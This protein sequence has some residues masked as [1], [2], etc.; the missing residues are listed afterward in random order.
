MRRSLTL[1]SDKLKPSTPA[2]RLTRPSNPGGSNCLSES[3]VRTLRS[4]DDRR[5]RAKNSKVDRHVFA[6]AKKW[7][8]NPRLS[9]HFLTPASRGCKEYH[10]LRVGGGRTSKG[11]TADAI[12]RQIIAE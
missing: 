5:R 8:I 2:A 12:Y 3:T 6:A 4:G 1:S 11:E 10:A 9:K 7:A